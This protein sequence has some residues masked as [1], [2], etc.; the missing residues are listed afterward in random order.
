VGS[1]G[2]PAAQ[3]AGESSAGSP[4]VQEDVE[5]GGADRPAAHEAHQDHNESVAVK[6]RR[7]PGEPSPAERDAHEC[8]R[9]RGAGARLAGGIAVRQ[10]PTTAVA[11]HAAAVVF[12]PQALQAS[13]AH[14]WRADAA[15]SFVHSSYLSCWTPERCDGYGGACVHGMA[16][17]F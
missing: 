16:R 5:M 6:A 10:R 1:A 3:Q 7:A 9:G 12:V 15:A 8:R 4:A 2:S 14:D 11:D 13:L 17:P